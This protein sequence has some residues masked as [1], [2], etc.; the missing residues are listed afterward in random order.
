LKVVSQ[1]VVANDHPALAGHFPGNPV[2]PGVVLLSLAEAAARELVG[3]SVR[4]ARLPVVK[5]MRPLLPDVPIDIAVEATEVDPLG[6]KFTISF[7]QH[8]KDQHSSDRDRIAATGSLQ[9]V[10]P[11]L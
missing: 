8:P 3:A 9:F 11:V 2:V 5:F 6:V 1:A 4:L 7:A 10:L